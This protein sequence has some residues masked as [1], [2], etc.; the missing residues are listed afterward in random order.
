MFHVGLYRPT[1][2]N[3][4]PSNFS[5]PSPDKDLTVPVSPVRLG[6]QSIKETKDKRELETEK[7]HTDPPEHRP[8]TPPAPKRRAPKAPAGTVTEASFLSPIRGLGITENK[9]PPLKAPRQSPVSHPIIPESPI[10][11]SEA[12]P[13]PSA[14]ITVEMEKQS[15]T[16][17][18]TKDDE[19]RE[20][21][22]FESRSGQPDD[23]ES[24]GIGKS[25]GSTVQ[26]DTKEESYS[27]NPG[28]KMESF[29]DRAEFTGSR[30][31]LSSTVT[32]E[33]EKQSRTSVFKRFSR[34]L[35]R[36][37]RRNK[38]KD[39]KIEDTPE[40]RASREHWLTE[41]EKQDA[42]EHL[43]EM[44]SDYYFHNDKPGTFETIGKRS[45][46]ET[47]WW[48]PP[49]SHYEAE[50]APS[51]ENSHTASDSKFPEVVVSS[52]GHCGKKYLEEEL[53]DGRVE[54]QEL[55]EDADPFEMVYDRNK[56]S[57]F[58]DMIKPGSTFLAV[59]T[60]IAGMPE[61]SNGQGN[62]V[63]KLRKAKR[64]S[65]K[66]RKSAMKG[67][68]DPPPPVTKPPQMATDVHY[69][70]AL[71]SR[72]VLGQIDQRWSD[73]K[74][75]ANGGSPRR[76]LPQPPTT[77]KA[78]RESKLHAPRGLG[79]DL[80]FRAYSKYLSWTEQLELQDHL[81]GPEFKGSYERTMSQAE[82]AN[83]M[84]QDRAE[85][86]GEMEWNFTENP[87]FQYEHWPKRNNPVE[88]KDADEDQFAAE[89]QRHS[90]NS[91]SM[92]I[93]R[94]QKYTNASI[95]L[96]KDL[97]LLFHHSKQTLQAGDEYSTNTNK[98]DSVVPVV[99]RDHSEEY[100]AHLGISLA[101]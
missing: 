66:D 55:Q 26:K 44:E 47:P 21:K 5:T 69:R 8:V 37:F 34:W 74:A 51:G 62:A 15:F 7:L 9:M 68:P 77:F 57:S 87:E 79:G 63:D 49:V 35:G 48:A 91:I 16:V 14:S 84:E 1:P 33:D 94:Y 73:I 50:L 97:S 98:L 80:D 88:Q 61:T 4:H 25:T 71:P 32:T 92:I 13:L 101:G 43:W 45:F 11:S 6:F 99:V 67:R 10:S 29:G 20:V 53:T 28:S 3:F 58:T 81:I 93:G 59:K 30:V 52:P 86:R 24:L 76:P 60:T 19:Q 82:T 75:Y 40:M 18:K 12:T 42:V 65:S 38:T 64:R 41:L 39:S 100:R 72:L 85:I 23:F 89:G 78:I 83:K 22:D 2:I 90:E 70:L 96:K 36:R 54:Q 46:L 95:N 17:E 31:S 27:I 56:L